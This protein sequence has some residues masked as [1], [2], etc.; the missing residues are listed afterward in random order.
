[1]Q[2]IVPFGETFNIKDYEFL[3]MNIH[4]IDE[5]EQRETQL[6]FELEKEI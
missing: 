1:M 5:E 6:I 2:G 3:N 4:N